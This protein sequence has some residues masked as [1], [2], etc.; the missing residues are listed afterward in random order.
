M[1][2]KLLITTDQFPFCLFFGEIL[3]KLLFNS[4]MDFLEENNL[5]NSNQ[6]GFRSNNSCESQLLSIVHDIYLSFDCY[7][8]PEVLDISKAFD[9]VWNEGLNYKIQSTGISDTPLKLI[10]VS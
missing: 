5:V 3:E 7:P 8:S 9:R 6:S 4:I 1:I 10:E 2:S